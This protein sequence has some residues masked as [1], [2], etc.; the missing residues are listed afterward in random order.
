MVAAGGIKTVS[1]KPEEIKKA[2]MGGVPA[3][4]PP[5]GNTAAPKVPKVAAPKVGGAPAGGAPGAGSA[6]PKVAPTTTGLKV[7]KPG[8]APAT[9]KPS[10]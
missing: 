9:P 4:K 5:T 2:A 3:A 6:A 8:Q 1:L 10:F 7:A